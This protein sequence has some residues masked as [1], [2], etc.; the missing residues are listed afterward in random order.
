MYQRA[1]MPQQTSAPRVTRMGTR[2]R[3]DCLFRHSSGGDEEDLEDY[4]GFF[5]WEL[6]LDETGCA[7]KP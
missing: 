7:E 6:S 4:N 3:R 2:R 5:A 1:D